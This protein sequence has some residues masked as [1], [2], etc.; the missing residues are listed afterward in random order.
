MSTLCVVSYSGSGSS[1][2]SLTVATPLGILREAFAG[3]DSRCS[4]G[5]ASGAEPLLPALPCRRRSHV[6]CGE[7][8]GPMLEEEDFGTQGFWG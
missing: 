5:G 6:H 7:A 8:A 3:F 1:D 4:G 2:T